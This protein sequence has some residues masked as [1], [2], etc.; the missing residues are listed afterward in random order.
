MGVRLMRGVLG[1]ALQAL[2]NASLCGAEMNVAVCSS[3]A[4][5]LAAQGV[6]RERLTVISNWADGE[7]I[8]PGASGQSAALPGGSA[9]S[10]SS[11]T[12]ATSVAPTWSTP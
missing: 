6:P 5:R 4:A 3:M 8:R 2:R 11:A 7:V 10:S 1:G 9:S 12:P